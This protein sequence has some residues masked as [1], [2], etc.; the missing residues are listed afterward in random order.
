ME[1][2]DRNL[3]LVVDAN[4]VAHLDKDELTRATGFFGDAFNRGCPYHR[5]T[6]TQWFV[7]LKL[8]AR[9]HASRQ[10]NGGQESTTLGMPI[11]SDFGLTVQRQKVQ[12]VPQRWQQGPGLRTL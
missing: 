3:L 5:V 6:D 7:K 11:V 8:A 4:F 2:R 1:L 9:P 10:G 12:P